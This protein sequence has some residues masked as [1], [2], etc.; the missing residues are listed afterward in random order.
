M[1]L[2]LLP[3]LLVL[4]ADALAEACIVH[5]QS[6]TLDVKVCQQN[7]SI[8]EQLFRDG[9]CKPEMPGQKVEVSYADQCPSGAF[10]VCNNAQVSNIAYRQDIHYYGV[11]TDARY[12]KPFCEGP[13]KG[14]WEGPSSSAGNSQG[15][16]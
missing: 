11:A 9:F 14:T 6:D 15:V 4:S 8:P 3:L 1:R 7:R 13:S 16:Q 5:S 2:C 10:G 12:L